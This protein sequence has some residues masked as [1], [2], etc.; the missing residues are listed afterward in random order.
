M[1]LT[2]VV[3]CTNE[4]TCRKT[5]RSLAQ[6]RTST[7]EV[8]VVLVGTAEQDQ[9]L[10]PLVHLI[11]HCPVLAVYVP[12]TS[13]GQQSWTVA[14]NQVL[15]DARLAPLG[16][17]LFCQSGSLFAPD[18]LEQIAPVLAQEADIVK[19]QIM[20]D[21]L[22]FAAPDAFDQL[23]TSPYACLCGLAALIF[24]ADFLRQH[25]LTFSDVD[26]CLST[27]FALRAA[28]LAA[29]RPDGIV[30][31]KAAKFYPAAR[32]INPVPNANLQSSLVHLHD[33][34]LQD[35]L[36]AAQ[37]AQ[38]WAALML[39][40]VLYSGELSSVPT[41]LSLISE[42]VKQF[43]GLKS[44]LTSEQ[45]QIFTASLAAVQLQLPT[46]LE[47][48]D[49]S[50]LFNLFDD[51]Q[52]ELLT[53]RLHS[54]RAQSRAYER[55]YRTLQERFGQ[56]LA[57]DHSTPA[58]P[59]EDIYLISPLCRL[60]GY[61]EMYELYFRRN[62]FIAH[63]EHIHLTPIYTEPFDGH[64]TR[65]YNSFLEYYDYSKEAWFIFV[66]GD[67]E[68][69]CDLH[70]VLATGDKMALLGPG[71]SVLR[72]VGGKVCPVFV[73]RT[74]SQR[75]DTAGFQGGPINLKLLGS[76]DIVDTVDSC[77]LAVHS[78]LIA[79]YQLRFDEAIVLDFLAEDFCAQARVKHGI[80]TKLW[81]LWGCHHSNSSGD[82]N[83]QSE[84]FYR[85][86]A[87]VAAKYPDLCL[88]GTCGFVGG[89]DP[90]AVLGVTS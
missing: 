90:E 4:Q 79:R 63:Q 27:L 12:H 16:Y 32:S 64:L 62:A 33:M 5:L 35:Q 80:K 7:L 2:F 59:P 21:D 60:P 9:W 73:G 19:V 36:S 13:L 43:G 74:D 77:C 56:H 10:K 39:D 69:T 72:R 14:L 61:E 11:P 45:W 28:R 34:M 23:N 31:C 42:L 47:Q 44:R 53:A 50:A 84:R 8:K 24:R 89:K 54:W 22:D 81:P 87:Y 66:H 17:T 25:E 68:F 67:Y 76:D 88:A 75:R 41:R 71:G 58:D 86:R 18:F 46:W 65:A 52:R 6:L 20:L 15:S 29:F 70:E 38:L 48:G 3:T 37:V 55:Y 51:M 40:L 78:S 82:P 30:W 83:R 49:H 26:T 85:T 57:S 1:L